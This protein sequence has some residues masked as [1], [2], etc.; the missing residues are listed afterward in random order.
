MYCLV[1]CL[2]LQDYFFS[3][4]GLTGRIQKEALCDLCG[5]FGH[6]EKD[7]KQTF[8]PK[9]NFFKPFHRKNFFKP[10]PKKDQYTNRNESFRRNQNY[11]FKMNSQRFMEK[12]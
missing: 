3:T 6:E 11:Y 8:L 4:M 1:Q 10:F 12:L 5:K 2:F 9:N 7:C